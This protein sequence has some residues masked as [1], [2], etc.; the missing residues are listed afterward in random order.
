MSLHEQID[1]V[2]GNVH[3]D[4]GQTM[5]DIKC[6]DRTHVIQIEHAPSILHIEVLSKS[7]RILDIL[8]LVV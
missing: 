1:V 5:L 6:C 7:S 3:S 4:V 2:V 8:N